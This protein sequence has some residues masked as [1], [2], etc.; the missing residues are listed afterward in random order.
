MEEIREK[1]SESPA[2]AKLRE[3]FE[4]CE[5]R[6]KNRSNTEENCAQE[7]LDFIHCQDVCVSISR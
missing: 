3:V 7:L 6:V 2:C 1:C 4:T 5:E